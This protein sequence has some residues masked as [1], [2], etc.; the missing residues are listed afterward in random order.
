MGQK[1]GFGGSYEV[2]FGPSECFRP[3]QKFGFDSVGG[4]A[5][6]DFDIDT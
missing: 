3:G 2:R 6:F 5:D 1:W 4:D